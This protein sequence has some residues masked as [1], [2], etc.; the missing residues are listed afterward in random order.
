MDRQLKYTQKVAP[1]IT[2]M[3]RKKKV[4]KVGWEQAADTML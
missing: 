2:I 1:A 4:G 3:Q